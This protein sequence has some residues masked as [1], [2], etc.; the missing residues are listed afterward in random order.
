MERCVTHVTFVAPRLLGESC[1]LQK[2][3]DLIAIV[4]PGIPIME[5]TPESESY[6]LGTRDV[7]SYRSGR[8]PLSSGELS[9]KLR[10]SDRQMDRRQRKSW[11][12]AVSIVLPISV[13][14]LFTHFSK[15]CVADPRLRQERPESERAGQW[16][17][18]RRRRPLRPR[19]DLDVFDQGLEGY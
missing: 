14:M 18:R 9:E 15:P 3:G 12:L 13:L 1:L 5:P 2:I 4:F 11:A 6:T 8:V 19:A 16:L 7:V 17:R 10:V